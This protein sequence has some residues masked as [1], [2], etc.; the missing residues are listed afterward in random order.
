[1]KTQYNAKK[2]QI[3][4]GTV[5]LSGL[6]GKLSLVDGLTL[7]PNN[8][9]C[10][11]RSKIKGSICEVC[12]GFA[13][14][15]QY[16]SCENC[17]AENARVLSLK[18]S[19]ESLEKIANG[20]RSTSGLVRFNSHGDVSNRQQVKNFYALAR[21]RPDLAF[22]FWSKVPALFKGLQVP[23]NCTNLLSTL[24]IDKAPKKLPAAFQKSFTVLSEDSPKINCGAKK[25]ATCRTCYSRETTSQLFELQK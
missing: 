22:G 5:S 15:K 4:E 20:F 3:P 12:F 7:S 19:K 18:L 23:S 21:L 9:G 13:T 14:L 17:W 16:S 10:L 6:S 2:I 24:Y 8:P 25:C 11:K 1:M